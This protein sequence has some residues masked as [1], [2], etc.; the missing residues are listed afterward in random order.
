MTDKTK[1]KVVE[2]TP[3]PEAA[4]KKKDLG[5]NDPKLIADRKEKAEKR[6]LLHTPPAED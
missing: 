6:R 2:D 5:I 1:I 3:K 4:P